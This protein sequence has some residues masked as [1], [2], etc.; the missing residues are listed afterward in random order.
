LILVTVGMQLPFDRLVMAMDEIAA[1]LDEQ[2]VGQIGASSYRPRNFSGR[3]SVPPGEF[4]ELFRQ[5]RL[6]VAHAGIGTVLNAQRHRKPIVLFPRRASFGEHRNDHQ[7]AT[8]S[9]LAQRR[10]IHIAWSDSELASLINVASLEPPEL[11]GGN[12]GRKQLIDGLRAY[13]ADPEA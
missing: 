8:C 1:R 2:V 5:A 13:L 9:Q 12:P 4:E 3:P 7:L 10:G 11:S 6:I